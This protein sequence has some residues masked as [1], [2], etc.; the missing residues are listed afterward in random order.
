M[1]EVSEQRFGRG[2]G[3]VAFLGTKVAVISLSS[4][5]VIPH[6][7]ETF[8]DISQTVLVFVK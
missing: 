8:D 4:L 1:L 3:V 6:D 7:T 2:E 5:V